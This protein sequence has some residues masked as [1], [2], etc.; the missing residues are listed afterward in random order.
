MQTAEH[1]R[2]GVCRA[3]AS[4]PTFQNEGRIS[5][6]P[7]AMSS[8]IAYKKPGKTIQESDFCSRMGA[9]HI[10]SRV[11]CCLLQSLAYA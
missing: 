3:A 1:R 9:S 7:E 5:V 11:R 10:G 8:E 6:T 2:T 4:P